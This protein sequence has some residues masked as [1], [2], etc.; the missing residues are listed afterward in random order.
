MKIVDKGPLKVSCL[1]VLIDSEQMLTF[2][3]KNSVNYELEEK[4]SIN[5]ITSS[6]WCHCHSSGIALIG[7]PPPQLEL[8]IDL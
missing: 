7:R 5:R 1:F 8:Q 6:I 4:M 3:L 2:F